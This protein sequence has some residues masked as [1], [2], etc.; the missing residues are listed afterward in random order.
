MRQE[1]LIELL[2][3]ASQEQIGLCVRTTNQNALLHR[4][5]LVQRE[6]RTPDIML[7]TPSIDNTI[8]IMRRSVELD[9]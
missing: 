9:P 4:L 1:T 5:Q 2:Q 7:C 8:F 3:R 6:L